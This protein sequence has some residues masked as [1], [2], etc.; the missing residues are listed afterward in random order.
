[1]NKTKLP[2]FI[3]THN[4]MI[5][6]DIIYIVHTQTPAF[7]AEAQPSSVVNFVNSPH[8]KFTVFNGKKI[9]VGAQTT[10]NDVFYVITVRVFFEDP[11]PHMDEKAQGSG[12]LMSRMGDWFHA[13]MKNLSK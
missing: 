9:S 12:G 10:V 6:N 3:A 1:M 4:P 5:G 13:Y 11:F 7:I 2:K 8:L